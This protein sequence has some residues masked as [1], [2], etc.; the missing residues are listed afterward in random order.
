MEYTTMIRMGA[1]IAW[2]PWEDSHTSEMRSRLT[3]ALLAVC[4]FHGKIPTSIVHQHQHG[5]PEMVQ[6]NIS[7]T[8]RGVRTN[9]LSRQTQQLPIPNNKYDCVLASVDGT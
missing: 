9:S 5:R 1:I 8:G 2:S 4:P 3:V 6:S 7:C